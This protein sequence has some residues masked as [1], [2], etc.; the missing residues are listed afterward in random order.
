MTTIEGL[1]EAVFFIVTAQRLYNK[2]TNRAA[3]RVV[4]S[5]VE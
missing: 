3:G 5:S 2:D 4:S 1:L